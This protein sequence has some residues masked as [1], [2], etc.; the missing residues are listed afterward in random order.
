VLSL[1]PSTQYLIQDA[2]AFAA[3][4]QEIST[5][6]H[7]TDS[8]RATLVVNGPV[9]NGEGHTTAID[10][11]CANCD[12][13]KLRHI[14]VRPCSV[15]QSHPPYLSA[16]TIRSM[17][18]VVEHLRLLAV[19]TLRWVATT[20][21]NS[22]SSY[23]RSTHAVGRVCISLRDRLPATMRS[24]RTTRLAL[25]VVLTSSSGLTVSA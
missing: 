12:G 5:L 9:Q 13:V 3:P 10:G 25:P 22:S 11:T 23:T 20:P 14:Q 6:G 18:L 21:T 24:S 8:T 2:I 16:L 4:N 19:E 7:P 15:I 1:C 17:E